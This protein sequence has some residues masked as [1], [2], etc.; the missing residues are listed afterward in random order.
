[1]A[2]SLPSRGVSLVLL[3]AFGLLALSMT[4]AGPA[5][6]RVIYRG[7]MIA[8]P[9]VFVAFLLGSLYFGVRHLIRA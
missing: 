4:S 2:P 8:I 6:G 1:M 3:V 7:Y 5:M 9:I